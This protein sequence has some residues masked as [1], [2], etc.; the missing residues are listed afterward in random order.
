MSDEKIITSQDVIDSLSDRIAELE[1]II[2][3]APHHEDCIIMWASES[4][5]CWKSKVEK[6]Q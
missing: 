3:A 6:A 4:C 5:D 2:E 1:A